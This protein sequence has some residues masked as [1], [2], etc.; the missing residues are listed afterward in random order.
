MLVQS[1]HAYK[2]SVLNLKANLLLIYLFQTGMHSS[3]CTAPECLVFYQ[4]MAVEYKYLKNA[5]LEAKHSEGNLAL[6]ALLG[7]RFSRQ[8]S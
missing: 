3:R 2:L 6:R 4:V 5:F 7:K 8:S 1:Y